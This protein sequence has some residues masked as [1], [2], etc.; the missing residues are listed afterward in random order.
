MAEMGS[1]PSNL[2][3]SEGGPT[4]KSGWCLVKVC[5]APLKLGE[6]LGCGVAGEEGREPLPTSPQAPP[7]WYCPAWCVCCPIATWAPRGGGSLCPC[8]AWSSG[9]SCAT[10]CI[11]IHWD[12]WGVLLNSLCGEGRGAPTP[13]RSLHVGA[14]PTSQAELCSTSRG[15]PREQLPGSVTFRTGAAGGLR[16]GVG[17]MPVDEALVALTRRV[18]PPP[19]GLRK[20]WMGA[21]KKQ[22]GGEKFVQARLLWGSWRLEGLALATHCFP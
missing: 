18:A 11:P 8:Q 7:Q 4:R 14:T 3:P 1:L 19:T 5:G 22:R 12:F 10:V 6:S 9:Q 15:S 13:L 2:I 20:G 21:E 17:W 16:M